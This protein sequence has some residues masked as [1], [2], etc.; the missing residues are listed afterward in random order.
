MK[1]TLPAKKLVPKIVMCDHDDT[2]GDA[3]GDADG[4]DDGDGDYHDESCHLARHCDNLCFAVELTPDAHGSA[5]LYTIEKVVPNLP[6][7][8]GCRFL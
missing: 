5:L 8:P 6:G 2:G 4:D 7:H 1:C 3:G